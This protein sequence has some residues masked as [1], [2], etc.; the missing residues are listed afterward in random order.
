MLRHIDANG[1]RTAVKVIGT[2]SP[3]LLAH[4]ATTDMTVFD[5]FSELLA[6]HHTVILY[7]QRDSGATTG[8]ASP[9][10]M[11]D[12]GDD[13]AALIA[14]LGYAKAHFV[15]VSLGGLVGEALAVRHPGRVDRLGLVF[16]YRIGHALAELSPEVTGRMRALSAD[17]DANAEK[18][19]QM[20][21]SPEF[22]AAN[23]GVI[24]RFRY[25]ANTPEQAPRRGA[26]LGA[27]ERLDL[28]RITAPTLVLAGGD[29]R[30][31]PVDHARTLASEIPGARLQV[32]DGVGHYGTLQ[33]S[34]VT[35]K[36][37]LDF[38]AGS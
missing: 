34:D 35:A 22:I 4:G 29:D 26:L 12:L 13:A 9:Y 25:R 3:V 31:I 16:T 23:P 24:A 27:G 8:P 30:L 6:A 14:A 37:L 19:A 36:A 21:L 28:A 5:G 15:G 10:T 17:R 1:T 32:L 38:L 11:L 20:F 2:G 18:I 7:D 33:A